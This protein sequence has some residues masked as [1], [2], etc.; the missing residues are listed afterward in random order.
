MIGPYSGKHKRVGRENSVS[1]FETGW[2]VY[3]EIMKTSKIMVR[4]CS[5]VPCYSVLI[6]GGKI[7]VQHEQGIL[8]VDDWAKFKAPAKIAILV[9]EMRQLVNKLLSMKVENPRLDISSSELVDVLLKI[10][11][12]DG[13]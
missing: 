2:L 3:S 13:M 12:T 9:R 4:D 1:N 6:F 10:L 7:D 5:M 8:M 11:T